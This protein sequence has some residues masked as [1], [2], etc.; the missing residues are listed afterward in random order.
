MFTELLNASQSLVNVIGGLL[1]LGSEHRA[2]I[3]EYLDSIGAVLTGIVER[4][5]KGEKANDLC[6]ELGVYSEKLGDIAKHT[7]PPED[8][9]QLSAALA[10]AVHSRAMLFYTDAPQLD[11]YDKYIDQLVQ[12]AGI[13]R[14][15][16]NTIRAK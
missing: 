14:A 10:Q 4:K 1:R 16:A 9:G 3:A 11:S 6:A 2:K 12:T 7:M 5:S 13:L 15:T 8:L